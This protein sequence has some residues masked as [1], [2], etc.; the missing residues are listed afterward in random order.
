VSRN[1][2]IK[3]RVDD[4][5][6]VRTRAAAVAS[7]PPQL[8]EQRD[9]FFVVGRGRLKVRT[10]GDGSGELIAYERS[11]ERGPR[12]SS[13]TRAECRD[14]AALC[15]ALARV[16]PVRGVVTKHREVFLAGR[17]RIHL[18]RVEQLGSFVELE[19]VLADGESPEAGER[20]AQ[21]L[22]KSLELSERDLVPDAYIDLLERSPAATD[23]RVSSSTST[24][25]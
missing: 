24:T 11:N 8:I 7:G 9:T 25:K 12:Q 10:F 14:A 17:T 2:E 5:G 22:L 1:I 4:V 3:A 6:V 19:V 15:E 21:E 23:Y 16:L 20:E 18:D 13:Y